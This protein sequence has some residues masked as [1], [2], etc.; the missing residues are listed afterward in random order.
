MDKRKMTPLMLA[1]QH[2]CYNIIKYILEKTKDT[3]YINFK[4]EEGLSALHY[5]TIGKHHECIELLLN[6]ELIEKNSE[7]KEKF[8]I[9][10]LAAGGGC[11]DTVRMIIDKGVH[12]TNDCFRRSP[13]MIALRNHHNDIF[14][15]LLQE[16]QTVSKKDYSNNTLLHYAAAYGNI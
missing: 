15:Q 2:G 13:L 10:H 14:F 8:T 11:L 6:D 4:G 12:L 3:H 16:N 7:T 5:A 1:A 9:L